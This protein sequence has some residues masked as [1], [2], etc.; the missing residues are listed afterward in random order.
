MKIRGRRYQ[1][2][3]EGIDD[4]HRTHIKLSYGDIPGE[5][6]GK[7]TYMPR[8]PEHGKMSGLPPILSTNPKE[9]SQ[10]AKMWRN[11]GWTV[12]ASALKP[13]HAKHFI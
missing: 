8:N 4:T 9:L 5:I 12:D 7:K 13:E 1:L 2:V 10:A 3:S 11:H 6:V